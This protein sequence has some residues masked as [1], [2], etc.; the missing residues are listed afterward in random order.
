LGQERFSYLLFAGGPEGHA[1]SS[2]HRIQWAHYYGDRDWM[3]VSAVQG[4]ETDN[5]GEGVFSTTRV[6]G[7]SLSGRHNLS[8]DWGLIWEVGS[9]R[10][11]DIYTRNGAYAGL[12]HSF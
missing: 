2:S 7:V 8:S 12:R 6:N 9:L 10:Q 1:I 5:L 4:R 11:G 3:G